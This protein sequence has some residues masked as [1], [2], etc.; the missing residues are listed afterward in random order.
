MDVDTDTSPWVALNV[1]DTY[2]TASRAGEY[3][4]YFSAN[5]DVLSVLRMYVAA[6]RSR[7]GAE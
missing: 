4:E 1:P 2:F 6:S 5:F 3:D 7:E